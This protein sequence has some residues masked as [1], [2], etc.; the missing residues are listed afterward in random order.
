V[1]CLYFLEEEGF[2]AFLN[3]SP[4]FLAFFSNLSWI[5]SE[6]HQFTY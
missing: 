5:K 6:V 2:S 3:P 1:C 4:H